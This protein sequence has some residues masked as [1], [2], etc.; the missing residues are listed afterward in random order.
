MTEL[1]VVG[2]GLFFFVTLVFPAIAK[3]RSFRRLSVYY[4]ELFSVPRR[5]SSTALALLCGAEIVI[6]TALLFRI[7]PVVTG[8]AAVGL[9]AGF[10]VVRTWIIVRSKGRAACGC[11]GS[12]TEVSM[13]ESLGSLVGTVV[14]AGAVGLWT[15]LAVA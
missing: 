7:F 2:L 8:L 10:L 15:A 6:G 11:A 12:T 1:L 3:V 5:L 14:L 9:L 4:A 13:S